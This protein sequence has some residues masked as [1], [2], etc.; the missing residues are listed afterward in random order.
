MGL[1]W[2]EV[3]ILSPRLQKRGRKPFLKG[4]SYLVS[5]LRETLIIYLLVSQ[6]VSS[7]WSAFHFTLLLTHLA[8]WH[9]TLARGIVRQ[10]DYRDRSEV[11]PPLTSKCTKKVRA[12]SP[13]QPTVKPSNVP[14]SPPQC[15]VFRFPPQNRCVHRRTVRSSREPRAPCNSFPAPQFR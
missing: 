8:H 3:Q 12:N 4:F 5:F 13:V 9:A 2:S 11:R 10:L 7:A 14:V 1:W 6:S 15:A